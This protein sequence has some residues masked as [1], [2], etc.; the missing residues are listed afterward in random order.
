M[1]GNVLTQAFPLLF[2]QY[3]L[4]EGQHLRSANT[5]GR[6]LNNQF[7]MNKTHPIGH[8]WYEKVSLL[9]DI[10]MKNVFGN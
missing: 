8:F 10:K 1:A 5:E 3:F 4:I 9:I 7:I 6:A 2:I